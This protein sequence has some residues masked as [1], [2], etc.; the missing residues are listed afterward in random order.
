MITVTKRARERA[1]V[2]RWQQQQR[3]QWQ[4][5]EEVC[6]LQLWWQTTKRAMARAARVKATATKR[7]MATNG[8]NT[9]NGYGKEGG[10]CL[11][12]ATMGTA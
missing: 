1:R 4:G 7:V 9:G 11:T 5:R 2:E 8:D 10:G 3:G 6:Q 12:V